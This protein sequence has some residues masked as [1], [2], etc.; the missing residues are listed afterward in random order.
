MP[1]EGGDAMRTVRNTYLWMLSCAVL[2][3]SCGRE[4]AYTYAYANQRPVR[5]GDG[6]ETA[7]LADVGMDPDPLRDLME[8]I[9]REE[10][11]N[12]HGIL[13]VKDGKIVF[14][15]KR[16]R[17]KAENKVKELALR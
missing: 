16:V 12:V 5:T 6:W 11:R 4:R 14:R 17:K 8:R 1:P 13:I 15:P 10:Y 3:V 9:E 2:L 7:D